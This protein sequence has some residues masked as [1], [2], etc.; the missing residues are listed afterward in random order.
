MID[1]AMIILILLFL[2]PYP[3][4]RLAALPD[5]AVTMCTLF[6]SETIFFCHA[7]QPTSSWKPG[8]TNQL[9]VQRPDANRFILAL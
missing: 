7:T 9:N 2:R 5:D 3:A 6:A 4:R 1:L 8:Y